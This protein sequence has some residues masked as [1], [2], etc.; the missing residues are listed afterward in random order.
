M[1]G[2]AEQDYVRGRPDVAGG[3]LEQLYGEHAPDAVRLAYLLTGDKELARDLVQDAFVRV[4]GRYADLRKRSAFRAYL[5][6]TV[7]NLARSHFR[8]Q[9]VE[10]RYLASQKDAP[11]RH[12]EGPD[13]AARDALRV[14]LLRLPYRQRAALV[15]RY[16]EDMSEEQAAE[17]LGC[18]AA[19][20]KSLVSRGMESLRQETVKQDLEDAT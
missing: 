14:A 2:I 20:V 1:N 6:T 3:K 16:Y 12:A 8:R 7:V 5:H 17:A 4:W 15:L 9:R 18:S 19:A 13:L 11:V 10:R